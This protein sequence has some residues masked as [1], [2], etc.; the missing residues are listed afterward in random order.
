MLLKHSLKAVLMLSLVF[1]VACKKENSMSFHDVEAVYYN[2]A[3]I[4]VSFRVGDAFTG[5]APVNLEQI[6]NENLISIYEDGEKLSNSEGAGT[7]V[8]RPTQFKVDL[9]VVVDISGS[10]EGKLET[11]KQSLSSFVT[12]TTKN[13][14]NGRDVRIAIH[15]FDGSEQT[16]QIIGFTSNVAELKKKIQTIAAGSDPSTNL[17]GAVVQSAEYMLEHEVEGNVSNNLKKKG[18]VFFTDGKDQAARASSAEAISALKSAKTSLDFVF[19]VAV[20]GESYGGAGFLE[21]FGQ[22]DKGYF[23]IDRNFK[24]LEGKFRQIALNLHKYADSYFMARVCSPKR[25]GTHYISFRIA[26]S[27]YASKN[28]EFNA[29]GFSSGCNVK[30]EEQWTNPKTNKYLSESA[31]L[32]YTETKAAEALFSK[33]KVGSSTVYFSKEARNPSANGGWV[34]NYSSFN[35]SSVACHLFFPEGASPVLDGTIM[36][37]VDYAS[38]N[39]KYNEGESFLGANFVTQNSIGD[40]YLLQCRELGALNTNSYLESVRF[41]F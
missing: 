29:N 3:N 23:L 41:S 11:V 21:N 39:G 26:G 13:N 32:N 19:G 18:L 7:S 27:N 28:I 24:E 33:I 8:N 38:F 15:T 36:T 6:K 1:T 12:E 37:I 16:Q 34:S 22:L 25:R 31:L 20:K 2:N 5:D 17:Y 30:T 40:V 14:K 35:G 10:V 9:L 4:M